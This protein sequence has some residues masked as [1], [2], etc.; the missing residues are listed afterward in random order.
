[1]AQRRILIGTTPELIYNSNP[2]RVRWTFQFVPSSIQ[3]GNTGRVHVGKGFPPGTV[4][5]SPNQGD[6]LN[7]GSAMEER[8]QFPNDPSHYTGQVWATASAADQE[9][10]VEEILE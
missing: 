8:A 3:A 9:C 7:A 4:L 10:V 1:M 6:V 5:G 2:R